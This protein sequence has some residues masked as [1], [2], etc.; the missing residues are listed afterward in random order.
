[1]IEKPQQDDYRN[2]NT[3]QPEKQT[4]THNTPPL[5][6]RGTPPPFLRAA[7][8]VWNPYDFWDVHLAVSLFQRW[9]A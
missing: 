8:V 2:R 1:M 4:A 6:A 5:I 9:A 3:Q 7:A